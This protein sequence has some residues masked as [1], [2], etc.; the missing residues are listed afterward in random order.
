MY[1]RYDT[2]SQVLYSLD[3]EIRWNEGDLNEQN[4]VPKYNRDRQYELNVRNL[5]D[6]GIELLS[7]RER[8]S[9]EKKSLEHYYVEYKALI[10]ERSPL[11]DDVRK[12]E[13]EIKKI[14]ML[15]KYEEYLLTLSEETW[16][17]KRESNLLNGEVEEDIF[18]WV[19]KK[20]QERLLEEG[21]LVE[22]SQLYRLD[23]GDCE[24]EYCRGWFT[25]SK[26]CECGNYKRFR[27]K[28][29]KNDESFSDILEFNIE[30]TIPLGYVTVN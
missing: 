13:T 18:T 23:R 24:D 22:R 27:W 7:K 4:S 9:K 16:E 28:Y 2:L 12:L 8:I 20:H 29:D 11:M 19:N 17:Y 1:S 26:R 21:Y 14:E 3:Q 15:P 30:S 25:N 10:K 6:K 5:R